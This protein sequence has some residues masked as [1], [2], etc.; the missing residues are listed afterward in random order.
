LRRESAT[1]ARW[2][3]RWFA[4]KALVE[5]LKNDGDQELL[6]ATVAI[7]L[8]R[9]D[10][11]RPGSK[12]RGAVQVL[13]PDGQVLQAESQ[14]ASTVSRTSGAPDEQLDDSN[15]HV[16]LPHRLI[17]LTIARLE[18]LRPPEDPKQERRD[19]SDDL[20][21]PRSH[22]FTAGATLVS[23]APPPHDMSHLEKVKVHSNGTSAQQQG[24]HDV[25]DDLKPL[26]ASTG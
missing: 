25:T 19:H 6:S 9:G 21:R 10:A 22:G 24:M 17:R 13:P 23:A 5:K 11:G 12:L 3:K 2:Q 15:A 26:A 20:A 1:L 18:V 14:R 7:L 4:A 8:S 16:F